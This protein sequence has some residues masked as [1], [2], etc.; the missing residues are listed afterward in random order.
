VPTESTLHKGGGVPFLSWW[1]KNGSS[2]ASESERLC[3]ERHPATQN[4]C[5]NHLSG[6]TGQPAKGAV[7][8]FSSHDGPSHLRPSHSSVIIHTPLL[9]YCY[10]NQTQADNQKGT[11]LILSSITGRRDMAAFLYNGKH[12]Q[13]G[14]VFITGYLKIF[15]WLASGHPVRPPWTPVVHRPHRPQAE[16]PE[17][18][19]C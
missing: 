18:K 15:S 8:D 5:T 4:Y 16:N 6:A 14:Y 1:L 9:V 3:Q 11:L 2:P 12:Q 7:F 17:L 19:G 13:E 10:T